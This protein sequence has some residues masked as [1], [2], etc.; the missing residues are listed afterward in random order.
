VLGRL[1]AA[2]MRE[3]VTY[4]LKDLTE[5]F[6]PKVLDVTDNS[7]GVP[8]LNAIKEDHITFG[9]DELSPKLLRVLRNVHELHI[10][11][12]THRPFDEVAP[13]I[14]RLTPGLHVFFT[15]LQGRSAYVPRSCIIAETDLV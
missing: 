14:S 8:G 15:P 5:P 2:T 1:H 7:F 11:W 3:R 12:Q 9:S 13:Y 4:I 10:R 6:D